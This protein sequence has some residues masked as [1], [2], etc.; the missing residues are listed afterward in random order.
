MFSVASFDG[1]MAFSVRED[2]PTKAC[3]P[4][5]KD[6]DGLI[7]GGGAEENNMYG[8][9]SFD[10]LQTFSTRIDDPTKA[11]RPF[12]RDRDGLV[13]SGGAAT[14][15][16]L[17]SCAPPQTMQ[18]CK[19]LRISIQARPIDCEPEAQAA[20]A[21][22]LIPLRWNRQA[23]FIVTVEFIDLK[24]APPPQAAVEPV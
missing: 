3:R 17:A 9:A 22:R 24:M 14:L 10:A 7:P 19:P 18:S 23:R 2:E 21:V 11:S 20:E 1:L 16:I 5:D 13:P 4:F 8:I 12:D 6:R 15:Y